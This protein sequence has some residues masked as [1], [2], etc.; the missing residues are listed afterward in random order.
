MSDDDGP[1]GA[2]E[3]YLRIKDFCR[4]SIASGDMTPSAEQA[5]LKI[6]TDWGDDAYNDRD[7]PLPDEVDEDTIARLVAEAEAG[8]P[9]WKLRPTRG[10]AKMVTPRIQ[11]DE[12][13]TLDDFFATGVESV[14]F[15][16]VGES[17]WYA[18]VRLASGEEWMLNFG[19]VNQRAKG[20]ARAE[21]A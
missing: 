3:L 6:L 18:L 11:L 17:Q 9:A 8:I 20:Y 13:G 19:A 4:D 5:L 21:I 1:A 12:D 15:E 14:H 7:R 16:A 2:L 10:M